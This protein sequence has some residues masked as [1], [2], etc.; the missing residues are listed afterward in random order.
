MDCVDCVGSPQF[1]VQKRKSGPVHEN[2]VSS[3]DS[4][5][6]VP[7]AIS[8]TKRKSKVIKLKDEPLG[9]WCEWWDWNYQSCI[10]DH[11]V[12]H[13]SL[14]ASDFDPTWR[15]I[16]QQINRARE[17]ITS[18]QITIDEIEAASG[19]AAAHLAVLFAAMTAA[20]PTT[21]EVAPT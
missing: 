8:E 7:A 21:P 9:L 4:G 10:L 13:D 14:P 17:T 12:H 16:L 5:S 11:F 18:Q 2:T 1:D 19:A 6:N 15:Q 20:V 3:T